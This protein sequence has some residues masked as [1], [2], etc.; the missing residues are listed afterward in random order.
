MMYRQLDDK[1][2]MT[3]R[4]RQHRV[5]LEGRSCLEKERG[6]GSETPRLSLAFWDQLSLRLTSMRVILRSTV[7]ARLTPFTFPHGVTQCYVNPLFHVSH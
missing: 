2:D 4:W 3:R 5:S 1:R 6:K 7:C